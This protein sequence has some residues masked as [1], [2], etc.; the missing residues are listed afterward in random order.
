MHEFEKLAKND[1]NIQIEKSKDGHQFVIRDYNEQTGKNEITLYQE[2]HNN[3]I[4][5]VKSVLT[6]DTTA[7]APTTTANTYLSESFSLVSA[8][9]QNH[10]KN[11][12]NY[13][14]KKPENN[15]Q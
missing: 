3:L 12:L 2:E 1:N 11:V 9:E 4:N 8:A 15:K 5:T 6:G 13:V 7:A 10:D 14:I